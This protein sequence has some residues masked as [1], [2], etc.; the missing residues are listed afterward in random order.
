VQAFFG[1]DARLWKNRW[2]TPQAFRICARYGEWGF[3]KEA[4]MTG[5]D[6]LVVGAGP[7]GLVLALW[8][9]KLG[10]G[11]RVVDK[12]SEPGTTSRALAIQARTLELYR[13][14]DLADAVVERAH[15]VPAVNLCTRGARKARVSFEEVGVGLT[16]YP[17]LR[18]FPQDE[19]E[20]LLIDRL[21]G[22]GVSVER[23]TELVGFKDAGDRIVAELRRADQGNET[24]EAAYIAGCDGARSIVR[25]TIGAGFPGGTY[26][27][28]FYV[29]D[30]TASGAPIDGELHVDLDE[31]DFLAIFPLAGKGRARLVGTVRDERAERS[32]ELR[33]EDVSDRAIK[34]LKVTVEQTNWFSTYHVHH[35]VAQQFR[36]GRAFLLGDAAHIHSPAG[37]QGMNTGIGDAINLAWK[38]KAALDG[39]SDALLDSY[40]TERIAFARRLVKTTDQAFTLATA[41]GDIA[42]LIRL[43]VAP[44]ILQTAFSFKTARTFAFR[45]VSQIN[46][47]Y[48]ASPLSQG[49]AGHVHG[50]D[51]MPWVVVDG[52]DNYAGLTKT[53]WQAHVYGAA[54]PELA[55]WCADQKVPL[56]VF[57]WAPQCAQAGLARDAVYLLRPD[58]Y[59]GLADE[60]GSA[61]VL[62]SYLRK[63]AMSN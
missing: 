12:T 54:R 55:A 37:G 36:K 19:H 34:N 42:D 48:R 24:L 40:E 38:L 57:P 62:R 63:G 51:R 47:N 9:T 49:A 8:L 58:T 1:L 18:I 41:E 61:D 46:V 32:D 30:V 5:C 13:Q 2:N 3:A 21:A 6:V 53:A 50:G 23:R 22:M 33:F 16:P 25:E 31:A 56:K 28:L 15:E 43:R 59:V 17:Y 39:A 14:L 26:E 10:A 44:A 35:R 52:V 4:T 27:H 45:T 11:V 20:R 7:T 29:A 60:S